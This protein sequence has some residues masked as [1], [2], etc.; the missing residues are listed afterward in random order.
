MLLDATVRR[1][2]ALYASVL[3]STACFPASTIYI[4]AMTWFGC[5]AFSQPGY[6]EIVVSTGHSPQGIDFSL[7][8][9]GSPAAD[10]AAQNASV[11]VVAGAADA[12][13][14]RPDTLIDGKLPDDGDQPAANFF[15][16]AGT[17]G[18]RIVL[19]FGRTVSLR[20]VSSFSWHPG[21]RAP[22]VYTLYSAPAK[23]TSNDEA[24]K[25]DESPSAES[26][27]AS[28]GW[29]RV[30]AVDTRSP[31]QP[32]ADLGGQHGATIRATEGELSDIR[33]L[34]FDISKTESDDA[35]GNTFFSEIDAIEAEAGQ[36]KPIEIDRSKFIRFTSDDG[37]YRFTIDA[38]DAP[39]L[40]PWATESLVPVVKQWY[41]SIIEQ[42]PSEGFQPYR[43]V[44]LKF[45][46][47]MG[48]TPASALRASVNL[49]TPWFRRELQREA[50]GAVVHELVHVTQQYDRASRRG[51][52]TSPTPGWLVEG[53]ADYIR[54]YGYE[55]QSRGA[56]IRGGNVD[57]AKYDASYR[58]TANFLNWVTVNHDKDIVKKLNA[59]AREGRYD[60]SIW[61]THTGKSVQELGL[62]WK[63]SLSD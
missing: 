18:G 33:Y 6:A 9:V 15:F 28:R 21:T 47:D 24:N 45:R 4:F 42:L 62:L 63:K 11:R 50:R 27:P 46:S 39:D 37:V 16:R 5:I 35:F 1:L 38:R 49:N 26:D 14:G 34:L 8:D 30:A 23:E 56:E 58:I 3:K 57:T 17:D 43:D 51:R 44:V 32:V 12:N 29:R 41:P 36:P 7:P 54:W 61:M 20:E 10:D 2:Y 22:Q 13:S 60:E 52:N 55:P 19:D 25:F 53:I 31:G 40:A 59:A 48:G